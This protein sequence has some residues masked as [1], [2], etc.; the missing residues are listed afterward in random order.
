MKKSKYKIL[1][2]P[3][4][5]TGVSKF[6]SVDPHTY[7]QNMY[8][9]D[10]WVD[11]VYDPPYHDDM[12]W[13]QYD[14][15]HYHR[16][17]GPDYDASKAVAKRLTGWGIPHIMDIDDY[18]LPTPDHPAHHIVKKNG[19]DVKIQE[20][21]RLAGYVTTTTKVFASEI[22]RQNKNVEIFPNAV[23]MEEKQ[24]IPQPTKSNK[25]R[26]GWLGGSSHIEDLNILHGLA[27]RVQSAKKDK[28]Q[29][30]LC[31]YDLRGSMTVFDE[32][33]GKQTQRPI[34]P[35]ESV[36]YKYEKLFTDDYRIVGG[37]YKNELLSFQK[38]GITGDLDSTYR[39]VW[40]KPI[41]TYASN[42]NYFDVSIAPLKEHIFNKVK[43]QLKVIE[44]AFHKK[45]LIAQDY[46]PYTVDCINAVQ[47]GGTIDPKGNALLVDTHKNHKQ[48]FQHVKRLIDNPSLVED[49]GEKLHESMAPYYNLKTVTEK[50][51]DWYKELIRKS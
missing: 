37:E 1:V 9:E 33:T 11:I 49:L 17:I 38:K 10:F 34:T 22:S 46:G 25:V 51:A 35:K 43:S 42:Y 8:P 21:I 45:A 36:W 44:A 6:R 2:L 13:K 30:V 15:V 32:R 24:Y 14:L 19:I 3:S 28:F 29:F 39:R 5:R 47:R 18:W 48:W 40:T 12:W 16:S 41:T 4:D 7:L 31:G 26:I 20:N 50:R 27:G 23:D